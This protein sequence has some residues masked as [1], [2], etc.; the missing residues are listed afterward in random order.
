MVKLIKLKG[1]VI[2]SE[3]GGRVKKEGQGEKDE[4]AVF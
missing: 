1:T 4:K 2:F 3:Y